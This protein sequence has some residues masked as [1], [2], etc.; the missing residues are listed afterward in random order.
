MSY[1]AISTM[2][3]AF[4]YTY[5]FSHI[6]YKRGEAIIFILRTETSYKYLNNSLD[7]YNFRDSLKVSN[8]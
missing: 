3:N 8:S 2:K 6:L 5:D 7:V 4:K 1:L